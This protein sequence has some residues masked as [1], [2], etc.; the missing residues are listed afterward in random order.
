MC[1]VEPVV[2]KTKMCVSLFLNVCISVHPH[3]NATMD[4]QNKM[5]QEK[6]R[7]WQDKWFILKIVSAYNIFY[8]LSVF[9][10]WITTWSLS[11]CESIWQNISIYT[12]APL[13]TLQT[14][15]PDH[16]MAVP[17]T[18]QEHLHHVRL[19]YYL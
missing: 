5:L 16:K 10:I 1:S 7:L 14:S 11:P 3:Y 9:W 6:V 2:K 17:D 8:V 4:F 15:T 12:I 18:T 19:V 13:Q